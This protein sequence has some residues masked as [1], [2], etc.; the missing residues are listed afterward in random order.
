MA[1]IESHQDLEDHPKLLLLCTKTGWNLEEAIG[2]LHRL[3]W[4]T[5]KYAEDGDLSRY[6]VSQPLG[7]LNCKLSPIELYKVLQE[8]GFIEESGLIHDWLDY[9]GRYLH[10]KYHSANPKRWKEIRKKH[11]AYLKSTFRPP[12]GPNNRTV[13]TLPNLPKTNKVKFLDFVLLK[14]EELK[15]L[16]DKLGEKNT[17][18]WIER[19]NNY[20]GSKGKKYHSHYHTIL[21]WHNRNPLPPARVGVVKIE[22]PEVPPAEREALSKQIHEFAV[23]LKTGKEKK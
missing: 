13:P 19:L 11:K 2:N 20:I 23:A 8:T 4:W 21:T 22:M 15:K 1:W 5:L 7:R 14:D 12:L 18:I 16:I 10:S 6:D 3:W 9:A 17:Q